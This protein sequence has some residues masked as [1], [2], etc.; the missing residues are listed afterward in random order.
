M[1]LTVLTGGARSGKSALAVE[2]AR[3]SGAA[4]TVIAT[5][6]ERDDEFRMRVAAHRA[7]RPRWPV[8]EEPLC[9]EAA[10]RSVPGER[11]V[12]VDCL[13]LWVSNLLEHGAGADAVETVAWSAAQAAA[14]RS[15]PTIAVTN[16]VGLGIVPVNSI[17]RAYRDLLGTV[18]ASWVAVSERAGLV[19]AGR[20]L[21]LERWTGRQW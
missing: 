16:E 14:N 10:L 12:V 19:V 7:A 4:V 13:S 17:A 1:P 11:C 21:P 3:D 9:L 2:L 8:V 20:V 18:N 6:E 15:G 5:A